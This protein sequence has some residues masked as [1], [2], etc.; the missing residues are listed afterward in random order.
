MDKMKETM[1]KETARNNLRQ[2]LREAYIKINS[3]KVANR[4]T[5][6][7]FG[8]S[9]EEATRFVNE[10]DEE[11]YIEQSKYTSVAEELIRKGLI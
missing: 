1:L 7:Q 5:M 4:M 9:E 11:V 2:Q 8:L 10:V 6:V 3:A